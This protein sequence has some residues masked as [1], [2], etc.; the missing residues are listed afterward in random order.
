MRK[1][2]EENHFLFIR[3]PARPR[4]RPRSCILETLFNII[5]HWA[6]AA[7]AAA[8][9]GPDGDALLFALRWLWTFSRAALFVV[10]LNENSAVA[11]GCS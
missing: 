11:P 7:A 1:T 4:P 10:L 3:S 8:A 5:N 9:K 6:A 2:N